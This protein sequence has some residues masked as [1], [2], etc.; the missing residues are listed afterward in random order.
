MWDVNE[1]VDGMEAKKQEKLF[2]RAFLRTMDPERAG[3][4]AGCRDGC[5]LLE[6]QSV[7]EQLEK[8][9][10]KLGVDKK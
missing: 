3:A 10:K 1:E 7:Q 4:E 2:C 5:S 9:D 8:L 6:R